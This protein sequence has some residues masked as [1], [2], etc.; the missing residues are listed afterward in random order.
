[1]ARVKSKA[2]AVDLRQQQTRITFA[3]ASALFVLALLLLMH[4]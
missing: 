1:M 2:K 4:P 3:A